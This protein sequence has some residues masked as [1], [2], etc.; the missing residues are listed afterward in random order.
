MANRSAHNS[1]NTARWD[2]KDVRRAQ[3]RTGGTTAP[4]RRKKKFP[5]G[6]YLACVGLVSVLLAG[7]GW[8][9]IN[10]LCSLNKAPVETVV[11]IEEN[12]SISSIASKLKDAGLINYK[13][14][15]CFVSGFLHADELIDPGT[16]RL[17][18]DMDYRALIRGMHSY[19]ST[20]TVTVTI[21]EGLT[22]EEVF[23]ILVENGVSLRSRLENAA[24]NADYP[25]YPFLQDS[26]KG[27]VNRV[28]GYLF[29]DTYEFYQNEDPAAAIGRML[30]N[31]KTRIEELAEDIEAAP[32]S[33][34]ELVIIA[35]LVEKESGVNDDYADFSSVIYNRLGSG[36]KLQLD[37]TIN[38]IK[39]TSTLH[40]SYDDMEIDSPYNTYRYAGLPV[41][42]ICSPSLKSLEAAVHP[43]R[44]NYWYWYAYEGVSYFF[45][46]DADFNYFAAMH[47]Y[48]ED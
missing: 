31:F 19:Q 23:D 27:S 6:L 12:E 21:Q 34:E 47:P 39:K 22:V 35:S 2:A 8:L 13:G 38:Y 40:I 44:T 15:F 1:E 4:R 30:A 33:L 10:D 32:Y 37:S 5:L 45:T 11:E 43:N 14:F 16:H 36:W 46:N 42:P 20:E 29:P 17:N 9:L 7:T 24:A 28:E 48:D 41:A 18:S 3:E 26:L 25:E